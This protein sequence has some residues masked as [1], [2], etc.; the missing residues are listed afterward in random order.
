[1]L[2]TN[3][4][5]AEQDVRRFPN[6]ASRTRGSEGRLLLAFGRSKAECNLEKFNLATN[7][8]STVEYN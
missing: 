6:A 4:K 3:S 1:M 5:I 2:T 7:K 8:Q